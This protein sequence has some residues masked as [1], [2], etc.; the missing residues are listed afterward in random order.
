MQ[1]LRG[2]IAGG[3]RNPVLVNL[4]M[5]CMLAGGWLSAREMVREAYPEASLD[6][7]AIEVAYPGASAL[8][9]ERA[10]CTPIE[11]SL[12]GVRGVRKISSSANENFGTVWVGLRS[13][14]KDPKATL[15]EV[16]DRVDL[17]TD[18]PVQAEKP[19]VYETFVRDAVI[20]VAIFGDV[21]EHTLKRMAQEVENDL[22]IYP[23]ISQLSLSG[24]RDDEIIIEISE[25]SLLAYN[26]TL[27]QVMA[28]VAKSSMDLPAGVI[29]TSEEEVT[30][31]V[32]GQ[33]YQAAD[34]EDLVVIEHGDAIVRLGDIAV[35]REGFEERVVRSRFNGEP[36]VVVQ[37]FKTPDED[38]TAIA[39][40]VRDY[41][42]SRQ[43]GLPE[44]LKMS[45]W[46]D[47]SREIDS[48]ISM[49]VQNGVIGI[50]LVFFTLALFLE[51]RLSFWVVVGIPVSF[52]GALIVMNLVGSTINM[53]SLFG[54]IMVSGIIVDDAIV[55]AEAVYA[56]RR[57]GESPELASING[58]H[59]MAL[60]VLG[61]SATTIIAFLPLLYVVGVM[62][63]L[64]Y[65][66]P[67]VV[68]GAIVSSTV[69]AFGM[70]PSHLCHR[71]PPGVP[72]REQPRHPLRVRLEAAIEHAVT[73]WYRPVY[74]LAMEFRAVTVSV[75]VFALLV[76]LGLVFGGRTPIVLLPK[77]DSSRIRVRVRFPEGS[78]VALAEETADRME[79]A[80]MAL[81]DDP[82]LH[83]ATGEPLVQQVHS[84]VGEFVDFLPVRGS[85][86]CETRIELVPAEVR[87]RHDELIMDRWREA[88]GPIHDATEFHMNSER[89]IWSDRPIEIRLLGH[90]L[91][92]MAGASERIQQKLREFE[93]VINVSDDLTL[94]K[95]EMR[96]TLKPT[97][98][99]LGLTLDDV[100]S[101]LRQGFFGGEAVRLYRGR[102]QV[103]VRV[104]YPD[105]ERRSLVD[106]E[107][108]RI[109]TPQGKEIPF[110]EVADVTWARGYA[111]IMHQDAKRRIRVAADIDHRLANTE[112]IIQTLEAGFL[113][114]VVADYDDITWELGGDREMM[115]E[116]L[117]SL[118]DG[119]IMALIA[120]YAV[121]A[122]MLRSYIQPIVIVSAVPFGLI[123][124]VAGHA[125]MGLD[126]TLM[127]LFGMVALSGVVVN[128]SLVLLDGINREVREGQ[129]VR[130]AVFAAG[131]LRFRA[132]VLT[133]VTTVAGLLPLLAERSSQAQSVIPMATSLAF[134]IMFA[135]VLTLF[136]VPALY[137][138]VNDARRM[139]HWLRYGGA[140]PQ[141]ELVEEATRDQRYRVES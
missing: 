53:V 15:K 17:I 39:Q 14:V 80:A 11:E 28:V 122:S 21:P 69:E 131:E 61:A 127:S 72:V 97:A 27:S 16:K 37:V 70:L 52:A 20:N 68:I 50:V 94:G 66:L 93:G 126:L 132:V 65:I 8:D 99:A 57:Q 125:F 133:S 34:Y 107:T 103:K 104:R 71:D 48:R 10:I 115:N 13:D 33:R 22:S 59:E 40:I 44:R 42:A 43:E 98:R 6:H 46:A 32:T 95:R 141:A 60:P 41:V 136:V 12:R 114:D 137:L 36:A 86:L 83:T 91:E 110:V 31:R 101:Q 112:R 51:L 19:T 120:I 45:V 130:E 121:L 78:P 118:F 124:A 106:L 102:D 88:I 108:L 7:I 135:T 140:Y 77:E 54:L 123:G 63:K 113:D 9:V 79:A 138:A 24:V 1:L 75:S 67:I 87:R 89:L 105:D 74:R 84:I 29:R 90:D 82:I 35:V 134:G 96:V 73:A 64:I 85:N 30:L 139:I 47:G 38:A 128:D 56:R 111:G 116:S 49:L 3:V 23:D 92:A 100:A 119:F 55:I 58:A 109:T 117:E 76:V 129:T 2:L 25:E 18:W 4:M 26:L 62:G 81:N 5:V